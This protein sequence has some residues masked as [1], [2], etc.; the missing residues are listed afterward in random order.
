MTTEQLLQKRYK[1]KGPYPFSPYGV[2]DIVEMDSAGDFLL[3]A[4]PYYGKTWVARNVIENY[5]N[6]FEEMPWWADRK[7]E[8]MPEYVKVDDEEDLL[9][10]QIIK[11]V[12]WKRTYGHICKIDHEH[13]NFIPVET[14]ILPATLE[15][16][17]TFKQSQN[18]H[19][20]QATR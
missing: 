4:Q 3:M 10:G 16:F 19:T 14:N 8:D 17:N 20:R 12:N 5:P 13:Y 18:D 15:Q 9:H 2:G 6:L 11:V 1:V 7:V